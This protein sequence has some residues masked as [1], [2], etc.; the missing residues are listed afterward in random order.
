MLPLPFTATA[1]V[2]APFTTPA[3]AQ[4]TA[5]V[6]APASKPVTASVTSPAA[7]VTG[8][9]GAPTDTQL[10]L[11]LLALVTLGH[12]LPIILTPSVQAPGKPGPLHGK[13]TTDG[14]RAYHGASPRSHLSH[15]PLVPL[16]LPPSHRPSATTILHHIGPP[17]PRSSATSVLRHL[18]PQPPRSSATSVF[19]RSRPSANSAPRDHGALQP[20]PSANSALRHHDPAPNRSSATSAPRHHG[21]PPSFGALQYRRGAKSAHCPSGEQ[22]HRH[23][24]PFT[25]ATSAWS[26]IGEEPHRSA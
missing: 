3:T 23:T 22:P 24:A 21:A 7:S 17:P 9:A 4:G 12:W 25:L 15:P 1:R 6:T 2:T 5:P 18:G 8:S 20:Q 14:H 11:A 10:A 26:L 13:P 16:G 19:R